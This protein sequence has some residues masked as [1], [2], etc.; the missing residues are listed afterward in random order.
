MSDVPSGQTAGLESLLN[1]LRASDAPQ[2]DAIG[3]HYIETLAQR[4]LTQSGEAHALLSDKLQQALEN[5]KASMAAAASQPDIRSQSPALASQ[6]SPL[7]ALLQDMARETPSSPAGHAHEWRTESPS[8]Q[9]FRQRLSKLSVQKQV[10][11][12]IAQAPQNAGPIN[13]HMLV[14][15]SLGLMRDLSPD[16]LNRF[17]A[18]VDTLLSLE[19]MV[20]AKGLPKKTSP[21][22]KSK[23]ESHEG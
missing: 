3:W 19:G 18:H 20:Q 15:R 12:A 21:S 7:S 2:R 10:T 17:M 22:H 11:Q 5:F 6:A 23:R 9:Q 14:L 13:S 16:Y 8:I 4:M 1:E